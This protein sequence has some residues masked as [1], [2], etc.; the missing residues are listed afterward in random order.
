MNNFVRAFKMSLRYR[1]TIG[2][3][4]AC[5]LVVALLWGANIGAMYPV[6][7]V[8]FKGQSLSQGIDQRIQDSEQLE[9]KLA[10]EIA[11]LQERIATAPAEEKTS[12]NVQIDRRQARSEAER[13]VLGWYR[14]AKPWIDRYVPRRSVSNSSGADLG[15][16][17]GD[18][19]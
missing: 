9:S 12:L 14:W 13:K 6:L 4:V 15:L 10:Q 18:D 17:G 7:D 2:G 16:D 5:V 19:R 3:I 8:I 1:W 11:E